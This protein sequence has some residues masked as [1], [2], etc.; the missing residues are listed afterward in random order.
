MNGRLFT[1]VNPDDDVVIAWGIEIAKAE[2]REALVY[3]PEPD[4]RRGSVSFHE[5]GEAAVNR[6]SA[7]EPLDLVWVG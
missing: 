6:W 1:L 3:F 5:S 7:F 4:N 2:S